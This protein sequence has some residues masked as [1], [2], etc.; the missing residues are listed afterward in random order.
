MEEPN[1]IPSYCNLFEGF[2][3]D[4]IGIVVRLRGELGK[5][6]QRMYRTYIN[7]RELPRMRGKREKETES[8]RGGERGVQWKML[9]E[10]LAVLE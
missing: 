2:N 10:A 6:D 4:E 3:G 7:T 5:E 1:R 9:A 8:V